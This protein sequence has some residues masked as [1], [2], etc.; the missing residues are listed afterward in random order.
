VGWRLGV[1]DVA[2]QLVDVGLHVPLLAQLG[3]EGI[4]G[5]RQL[6]HLVS[7]TDVELLVVVPGGGGLGRCG[8]PHHRLQHPL[9]QVV[10]EREGEEEGDEPDPEEDPAD[11][12]KGRQLDVDRGEV[13]DQTDGSLRGVHQRPRVG[14]P[15]APL[16]LHRELCGLA[17]PEGRP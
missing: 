13:D 8:E 15:L 4:E 14:Q 5:V 3:E 10:G 12:A 6:S 17:P 2:R 16:E 7:L 11:A 9:R 1:G